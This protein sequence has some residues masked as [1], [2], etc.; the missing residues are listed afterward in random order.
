VQSKAPQT[1]L[2]VV[3]SG[4]PANA[5]PRSRKLSARPLTSATS[6]S[7]AH[8]GTCTSRVRL[9]ATCSS[10]HSLVGLHGFAFCEHAPR[11]RFAMAMPRPARLW[12]RLVQNR[13]RGTPGTLP[14]SRTGCAAPSSGRTCRTAASGAQHETLT[15]PR[16]EARKT[17]FCF[18][19]P[20]CKMNRVFSILRQSRIFGVRNLCSL[21]S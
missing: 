16:P 13:A 8:A 7:L 9:H 10:P 15:R 3:R 1:P 19:H 21:F 11:R 5:H 18:S 20:M 14:R 6:V 17:F 2:H 12:A 4:L